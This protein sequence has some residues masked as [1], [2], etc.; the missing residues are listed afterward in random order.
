MHA[1]QVKTE[2]VDVVFLDPILHALNHELAHS[3]AFARRLVTAT[4]AVAVGAVGVLAVV[5]IGTRALEVAA[6]DVPG[7]V[8]HH[9]E[10]HLNASLVQSLYHLLEFVDTYFGL[11]GVGGVSAFGYIVVYRV[12]AP[13]ILRLIQARLID[14]C[15]VK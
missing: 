6:V 8:V 2:T 15:I 12:I 5:V 4:A 11:V 7:V 10:N 14:R 9:V 13:V 1:H 3:L